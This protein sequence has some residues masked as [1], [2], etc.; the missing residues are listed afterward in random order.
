MLSWHSDA[1]RGGI[2][3]A[4][5][6]G[7]WTIRMVQPLTLDWN[8]LLNVERQAISFEQLHSQ[9]QRLDQAMRAAQEAQDE[10]DGVSP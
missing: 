2:Q 6:D 9:H 1:R 7:R 10:L 3:V 4:S 5:D 8:L